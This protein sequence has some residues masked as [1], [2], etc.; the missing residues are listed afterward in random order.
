VWLPWPL[1]A[2]WLVTGVRAVGDERSGVVA[3]VLACSGP[4]PTPPDD[5][6]A[7]H[8]AELLLVAEQ[9]AVGLGAFLAGLPDIDPGERIAASAPLAKVFANGHPTPLWHV[10][11]A[12]GRAV[13]VGEAAGVW[14]WFL[15]WP[16]SAGALLLDDLHLVDAAEPGHVLDPPVGALSPRLA[17]PVVPS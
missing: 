14:L 6:P 16:G 10:P 15:L 4:N 17:W 11:V 5:R 8:A 1:P 3:T 9:P 12:D 7:E 13:Y 2:G